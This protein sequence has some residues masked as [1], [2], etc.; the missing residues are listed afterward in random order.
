[1]CSLHSNPEIRASVPAAQGAVLAH[2]LVY[3]WQQQVRDEI[4]V[5]PSHYGA[6]K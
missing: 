3:M 2:G 6:I 4:P 1:M 5:T